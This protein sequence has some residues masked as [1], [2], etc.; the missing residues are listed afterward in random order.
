MLKIGDKIEITDGSYLFGV[1]NGKYSMHP[2]F[3]NKELFT[4]VEINLS[5]A[6]KSLVDYEKFGHPDT[7]ASILITDNEGGFWFTPRRFIVQTTPKHTIII[8]GNPIKISDN[9]FEALRKQFL[10]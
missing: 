6:R 7:I 9:S 2:R 3:R 8:D 5:T 10:R 4:V 1:K